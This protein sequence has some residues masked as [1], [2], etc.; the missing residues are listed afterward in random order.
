MRP[1]L[2]T[3]VAGLCLVLITGCGVTKPSKYYLLTPVEQNSAGTS[4][5]PANVLGIGPVAFPAYLDRPQIVVRSGSNQLDYADSHRWAEPLKA[6]FSHTLS[7]NLSIM[8]PVERA[9]IY[10]WSRSTVLDYQ[11]I[12]NVSRFDADA[13]GTVILTADWE[14]IRS[15]D[16]KSM[17]QDK[18]TYSEAAGSSDYP[19]IVA[20]QSRAV[21]QLSRDIAAA[22]SSAGLPVD[23]PG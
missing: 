22:I 14:I 18:A 2:H 4:G 17:D 5:D 16:S 23:Q 15:S 8:L 13:S 6:A 9:V 21:E 1:I 19:A 10:P 12:V 7:E 3:L 11:V 20:A